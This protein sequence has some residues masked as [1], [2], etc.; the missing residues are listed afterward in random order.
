M[1]FPLSCHP[2]PVH[3]NKSQRDGGQEAENIIFFAEPRGKGAGDDVAVGVI[4]KVKVGLQGLVEKVD[5][6]RGPEQEGQHLR[7]PAHAGAVA[8]HYQQ[9]RIQHQQ[10]VDADR[11]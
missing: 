6:Q 7:H 5:G 11:V 9:N 10:C 2:W 1:S 4:Q 3:H 8:A